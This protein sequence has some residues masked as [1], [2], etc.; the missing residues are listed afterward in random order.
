MEKEVKVQSSEESSRE[1]QTETV[2]NP[3]ESSSNS[4][5]KK[6][7]YFG[8]LVCLCVCKQ[9]EQLLARTGCDERATRPIP[10]RFTFIVLET[11]KDKSLK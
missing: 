7:S 6:K 4:G 3:L 1:K 11:R 9:R 5:E 8:K 2:K 10:K